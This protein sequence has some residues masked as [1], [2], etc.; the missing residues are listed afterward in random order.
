MRSLLRRALRV[1]LAALAVG[2]AAL[3][4]LTARDVLQ[5]ADTFRRDDLRF[6]VLPTEQDLW[7]IEDG[8]A[9]PLRRVL[10]VNDDLEFRRA[11]RLFL[12]S[13]RRPASY[14]PTIISSRAEAQ[15]AAA[16]AERTGLDR[17]LA[18]RLTNLS[19]I[20]SFEESLGDP[21]NG[22][23][24]MRRSLEELRRAIGIDPGN[25]Q[26]KFNLELLLRLLEP[27]G[28]QR[29][30]RLGVGSGSDESAGASAAAGGAGY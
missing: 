8:N 27:E 26:A 25:E 3:S 11:A 2:L 20:L 6:R 13:R 23:V 22:P 4:V 16:T 28:Q 21:E 14:D 9:F 18:S 30:D 1:V 7:Q 15:A 29:R 12:L 5:A 10:D 17:D 24:L 19:G